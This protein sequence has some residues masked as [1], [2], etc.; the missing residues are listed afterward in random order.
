MGKMFKISQ[1]PYE[2]DVKLFKRSSITVHPGLTVLVGCNGAGKTTMLRQI[3][4]Q[5]K[6]ENAYFHWYDNHSDGDRS[7]MGRFMVG[8]N[9][10]AFATMA[11]SSEGERIWI[12]LHEQAAK[13]G[14]LVTKAGNNDVFILMD[15]VDSGFSIDNVAELKERLFKLII[16]DHSSKGGNVYIIVTANSYEMARGE[17]CIDVIRCKHVKFPDY[18]TYRMFILDSSKKKD[19]RMKGDENA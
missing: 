10:G 19:E 5:L 1:E 17:E 9:I 8:N 13:I 16:S 3:R 18:E 11:I 7:A 4:D 12:V 2:E 6:S 15:A 14:Q